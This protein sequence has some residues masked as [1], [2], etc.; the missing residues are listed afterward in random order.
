MLIL[1]QQCLYLVPSIRL[2]I[3]QIFLLLIRTY[4]F[5]YQYCFFHFTILYVGL[6]YI[7]YVEVHFAVARFKLVV[8][9]YHCA[10]LVVRFSQQKNIIEATST[11]LLS[12]YIVNGTFEFSYFAPISRSD[13]KVVEDFFLS[14]IERNTRLH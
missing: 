12:I 1:Y 14:K 9:F 7:A 6:T 11:S 2:P 10:V 8:K 4:L 5:F 3:S 13:S